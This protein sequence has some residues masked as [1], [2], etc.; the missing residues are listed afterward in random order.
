MKKFEYKL[1]LPRKDLVT[2]EQAEDIF[3]ALGSEGWE[4]CMSDNGTCLFKRELSE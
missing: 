1:T 2:L 4:F 3:N